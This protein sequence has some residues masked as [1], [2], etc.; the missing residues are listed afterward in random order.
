VL[1]VRRA[2][3]ASGT[4]HRAGL[5]MNS[6]QA[7]ILFLLVAAAV[8][9]WALGNG[10]LGDAGDTSNDDVAGD[11][12]TGSAEEDLTNL[13]GG[14]LNTTPNSGNRAAFLQMI[15]QSEVGATLIEETDNGYNVLC[16]ATAGNPL[17]FSDYSTHPDILNQALDSTAAGLYQINHP[18][19][20]TLCNQTG[21]SD[22]SPS[23]QDAMAIQLITNKG[24]LADVDAGNF[25]SAIAKCKG[26]WASFAGATATLPNG[27]PQPTNSLSTL[28]AF[29]QNAGGIISS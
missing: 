23:T 19:W 26:V 6:N 8:T 5:L 16:G 2:G 15:G 21:L 1:V 3:M 13:L 11:P 17:T 24:A 4:G 20:L 22:F 18:T 9:V 27:Q 10:T 28:A 29:F 7:G 12:L 25:T 14:T